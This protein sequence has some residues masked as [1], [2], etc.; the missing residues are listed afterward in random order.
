MGWLRNFATKWNN[1]SVALFNDFAAVGSASERGRES[2]PEA[3]FSEVLAAAG[4]ALN[5]PRR[6]SRNE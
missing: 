4:H 2:K 5:L 1:D 6:Q 3:D